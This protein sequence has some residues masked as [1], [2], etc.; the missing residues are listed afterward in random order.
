MKIKKGVNLPDIRP[1]IWFALGV[2][3][4][5]LDQLK[6]GELVVTSLRDGRHAPNSFHYA[7]LACDIRTRHF[8]PAALADLVRYLKAR[9]DLKGYDVVAESDHLHIEWDPKKGDQPWLEE[10]S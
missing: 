5:E 7:G 2:V 1:Q 10:V 8:T 4:N 9:L 3:E 6:A